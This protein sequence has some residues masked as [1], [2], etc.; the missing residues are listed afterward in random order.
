MTKPVV[1][2]HLTTSDDRTSRAKAVVASGSFYTIVRESALPHGT[3]FAR[4]RRPLPLGT[5]RRGATLEMVGE[6]ILRIRI[7]RKQ[8]RSAAYVARELSKEMLI[9]AETM[10]AWDISVVNR[11]G[12]TQVLVGRDM[13][14]PEVTEIDSV[15]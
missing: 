4:Y 15:M 12:R 7:G 14:D 6:T 13:R 5:A 10:Q 1:E 2:V 11:K 3:P 8:I 9:G